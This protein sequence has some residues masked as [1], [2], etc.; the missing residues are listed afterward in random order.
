MQSP[1]GLIRDASARDTTSCI[2]KRGL[3]TGARSILVGGRW[4]MRTEETSGRI[5]ADGY[6]DHTGVHERFEK[7]GSTPMSSTPAELRKHYKLWIGI[8]G[9]IAKDVGLKPQ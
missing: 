8:F 1:W 3:A 9:K 2:Y 6:F 4:G 7:A 5:R